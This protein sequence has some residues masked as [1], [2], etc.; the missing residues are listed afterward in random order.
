LKIW[1][2]LIT[3]EASHTIKGGVYLYATSAGSA[4]GKSGGDY[5]ASGSGTCTFREAW[6]KR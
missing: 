3:S 6:L 1:F 4:R 5:E 2:H